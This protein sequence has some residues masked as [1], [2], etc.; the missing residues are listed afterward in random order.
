MKIFI[1][2]YSLY[3]HV[4]KMAEAMKEGATQVSGAEVYLYR[5]P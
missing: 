4:Y 5:V 3:G 1:V 2:Y